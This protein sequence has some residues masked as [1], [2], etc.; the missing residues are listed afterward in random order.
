MKENKKARKAQEAID[1]PSDVAAN[2]KDDNK[3][4]N[5]DPDVMAIQGKICSSKHKNSNFN[6]N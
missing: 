3:T 4:P 6:R 5:V 1:K 2:I